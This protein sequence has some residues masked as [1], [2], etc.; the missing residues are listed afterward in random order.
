VPC[1]RRVCAGYHGNSL[2]DLSWRMV[3][4]DEIRSIEET[5]ELT[6]QKQRQDVVLSP[7][8]CVPHF[9]RNI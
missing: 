1:G 7:T 9:Q 6:D 5:V 3:G 4:Y 2:N 8:T